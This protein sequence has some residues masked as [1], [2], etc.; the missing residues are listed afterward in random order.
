MTVAYFMIHL[1]GGALPLQ[2]GGELAALYC[3]LFLFI[4]SRGSGNWSMDSQRN[5]D[6]A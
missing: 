4:A 3:W 6:T 2:S 1:K 5:K